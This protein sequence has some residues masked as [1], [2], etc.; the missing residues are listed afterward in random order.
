MVDMHEVLRLLDLDRH[1]VISVSL[2]VDPR[3]PEHQVVRPAYLIWLRNAL[4]PLVGGLW[5]DPQRQ[6]EEDANSILSFVE[7]WSGRPA[8]LPG[9]GLAIFAAPHL[10]V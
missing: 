2:D 1:D 4:R 3:K 7:G 5:G 8:L 6:A 9:R 10:W